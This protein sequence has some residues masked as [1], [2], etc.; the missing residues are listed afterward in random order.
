MKLRVSTNETPGSFGV[1]VWIW[2]VTK[3]NNRGNNSMKIENANSVVCANH[4]CKML[5]VARIR[6]SLTG[7]GALFG[8]F[9]N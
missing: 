7:I 1:F 8:R 2:L 6:K 9:V 3:Y 5:T 4:N